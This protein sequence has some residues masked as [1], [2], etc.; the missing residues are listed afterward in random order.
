MIVTVSFCCFQM[1]NDGVFTTQDDMIVEN[2]INIDQ[3]PST[4]ISNNKSGRDGSVKIDNYTVR[5]FW[6]YR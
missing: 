2:L 6:I 4:S 1:N 3:F 5:G